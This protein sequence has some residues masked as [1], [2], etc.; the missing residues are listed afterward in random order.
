MRRVPILLLLLIVAMAQLALA[1]DEVR[2]AKAAVGVVPKLAR[3]QPVVGSI[4]V[5]P[6][7]TVQNEE[8]LLKHIAD[9]KGFNP[10]DLERVGRIFLSRAPQPGRSRA[11]SQRFIRKMLTAH[12]A[13]GSW[14]IPENVNVVRDARRISTDQL[15]ELFTDAVC[16]QTNLPAERVEIGR[17]N[18]RKDLLVP[19][20]DAHL[21]VEFRPGEDFRGLTTG[22]VTVM[23]R[24]R[25]VQD[26][27][28]TADV[29]VSA[30]AVSVTRTVERGE[31]IGAADIQLK[32]V[33]LSEVSRDVLTDENDVIGM[34]A[35]TLLNPGDVLTDAKLEAPLMIERGQMVKL[36]VTTPYMQVETKGIAQ[37]K[38]RRKQMIKVLNISSNKIVYGRVVDSGTVAMDY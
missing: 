14:N 25:S 20:G 1:A 9:I 28:V 38:G 29:R 30:F 4:S 26:V 11:F 16:L 18:V 24:N 8:V 37:Q 19:G 32:D 21:N 10:D 12:N 2:V 17:M 3:K 36:M 5:R 34:A 15:R 33:V 7:V 22:K 27:Y 35:A 31:T 6:E 23:Q 13:G